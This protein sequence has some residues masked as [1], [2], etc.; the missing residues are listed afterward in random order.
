[1]KWNPVEEKDE[2]KYVCSRDLVA[3]DACM[4]RAFCAMK[5][6]TQLKLRI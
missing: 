3:A 5:K 1:M 2:T 4:V 6:S